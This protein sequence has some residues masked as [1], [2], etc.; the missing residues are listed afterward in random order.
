MRGPADQNAQVYST[1]EPPGGQTPYCTFP[2]TLALALLVVPPYS[3]GDPCKILTTAGSTY[4]ADPYSILAASL[5][6]VYSADDPLVQPF[7]AT[8]MAGYEGANPLQ[9]SLEV[10]NGNHAYFYD[11]WWQQRAALL[12][13]EKTLA[14]T[15]DRGGRRPADG[16]SDARRSA[17][18]RP[19]R[20]TREPRPR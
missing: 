14:D 10:R 20:P 13:F 9:L 1:A 8:M 4:G 16:Q 19:A 6:N 3:K 12:Y 7:H 2:A 17:V 18:R 15:G 11:R 5:L